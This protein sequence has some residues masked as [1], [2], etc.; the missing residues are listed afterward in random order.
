MAAHVQVCDLGRVGQPPQWNLAR[1]QRLD[2]GWAGAASRARRDDAGVTEYE[3]DDAETTRAA[4]R[5]ARRKIVVADG[6]KL[7]AVA[8]VRLCSIDQIDVVVT[9]RDAPPVQVAALREA[10]VEVLLA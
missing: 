10:G 1:Q 6:S 4:L 8:F 9:D 2:V 3:F 5:S 7:G